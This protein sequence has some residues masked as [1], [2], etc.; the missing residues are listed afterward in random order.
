MELAILKFCEFGVCH[1]SFEGGFGLST[2]SLGLANNLNMW[3]ELVWISWIIELAPLAKW[4]LQ[5]KTMIWN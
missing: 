3:Q 2:I 4:V 1:G 5:A